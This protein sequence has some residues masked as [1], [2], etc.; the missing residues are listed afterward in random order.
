MEEPSRSRPPPRDLLIAA[1]AVLV[2]A[3][4][5]VAACLLA[6]ALLLGGAA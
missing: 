1:F 2:L 6:L 5:G 3:V 4:V